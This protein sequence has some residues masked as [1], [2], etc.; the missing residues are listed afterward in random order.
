M[1]IYFFHYISKYK[2]IKNSLKESQKVAYKI[3][4]LV[5]SLLVAFVAAWLIKTYI[6][7]VSVV[8]TG[9]MI[10]TLIGGVNGEWNERLFVNKYIYRFSLPQRGD[11]VVFSSPHLDG[12]DYVKRCIGLPGDIIQIIRGK[13]LIN[14]KPLVLA[15]VNIQYDYDFYGP[16]EVP[17]DHYFVLG[18]NRPNSN[19]SRYWGFVAQEDLIGSAVFTWWPLDRMR[20]LK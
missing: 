16:V 9:S 15:G 7:Q 8:P 18:D 5:E 20:R 17:K 12:K 13:V 2:K 10:P 14:D 19:D 11:I 4:S 6:I 1:K 3:I